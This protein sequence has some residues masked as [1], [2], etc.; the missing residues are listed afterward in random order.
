MHWTLQC[1]LGS[2]PNSVD[3][4]AKLSAKMG[5][6]G[7]VVMGRGS[8]LIPAPYTGWTF[9]HIPICCKIFNVRLKKRKK[10]KKRPGVGPFS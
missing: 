5:I 4:G 9:F 6:P 8:V 2:R 10:M 3:T 7:L 1:K